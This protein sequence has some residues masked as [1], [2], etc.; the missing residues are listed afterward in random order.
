M[1]LNR[2]VWLVRLAMAFQTLPQGLSPTVELA[3]APIGL[4]TANLLLIK[5][6]GSQP[7]V[8]FQT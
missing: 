1:P 5:R 7:R 2:T 3:N 4:A 8:F 6:L